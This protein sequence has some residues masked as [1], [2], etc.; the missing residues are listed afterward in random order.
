MAPDIAAK[1]ARMTASVKLGIF[2]LIYAGTAALLFPESF[3]A[4]FGETRLRLYYLLMPLMVFL[5]LAI[6][7]VINRPRSP[8]GFVRD[9]LAARGIGATS[10]ILIFMACVAAYTAYKH[11]F[12]GLVTFFADPLFAR[13]DAAIHFG[14][15][16]RWA[17]SVPVPPALDRLL[18][19]LYSQLWLILLAG[20]VVFAA[21]LENAAAR[22]RYFLALT[23][24]AILLG[25]A[26]RLLGSSAGPIFYDRMFGG[27]RFADLITALKASNAG[28]DTLRITDYLYSSYTDN[29]TV[30]GSG[31]SA[32][33]SFHVAIV[34]LNALFLWS[35]NRWVGA[36]AWLYAAVILFGSVYSGWHYAIDGYVSIAAV[37]LIWRWASR[38]TYNWL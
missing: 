25:V 19:V 26:V 16:W 35:L 34:T 36:I 31:I 20:V 23:T 32:M 5:G 17:R 22:Q 8:L 27:D 1:P 21:W 13:V 24:T 11:D 38:R 29:V 3:L 14:D 10:T 2:C 37:L 18:Y 9:K 7:G 4:A 6:A 28:P 33:P 30:V 12:S 15:P